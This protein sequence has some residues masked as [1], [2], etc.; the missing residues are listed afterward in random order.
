[1][2]T[3]ITGAAGFIGSHL[4]ERLLAEG[5]A[6]AE[7]KRDVKT[8]VRELE[9]ALRIFERF[10]HCSAVSAAHND[11]GYVYSEWSQNVSCP[12]GREWRDIGVGRTLGS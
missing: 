8:A 7:S 10:G 6:V 11:L 1:M 4:S 3:L 5:D 2:K 12:F 9:A